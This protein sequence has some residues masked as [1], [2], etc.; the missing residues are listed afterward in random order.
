VE[1]RKEELV[2]LPTN[3]HSTST[4]KVYGNIL[5]TMA[6]NFMASRSRCVA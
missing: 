1:P 6:L 2:S 5:M 3:G 4:R